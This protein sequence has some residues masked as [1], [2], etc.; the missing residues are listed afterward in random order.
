[1]GRVGEVRLTPVCVNKRITN[2][3]NS[4]DLLKSALPSTLDLHRALLQTA[5]GLIEKRQIRTLASFRM[6]VLK[7]GPD[8]GFF[9]HPSA[10]T[11]LALWC[12]EA[13]YEQERE[14]RKKRHL[15]LVVACLNEKRDVYVVVGVG[16]CKGA[17]RTSKAKEEKRAEKAREKAKAKAAK[18]DGLDDDEEKEE[19]EDDDSSDEEEDP[20]AVRAATKNRFGIAFQEVAANTNARIRIDSFEACVVEVK[21]EDLVGFFEEL[22]T[23]VVVGG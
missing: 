9:Q 12:A 8:L 19:T 13:I 18:A 14:E 21:R 2:N 5:T 15:P 4:V 16:I 7:E 3:L 17:N 1:M 23:R 20:M 10:L 6:A 22:S 11:K